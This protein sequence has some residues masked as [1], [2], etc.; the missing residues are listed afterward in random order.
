[1]SDDRVRSHASQSGHQ[2]PFVSV[3]PATKSASE[4]AA[5]SFVQYWYL[6]AAGGLT[7]PAIWPDPASTKRSG[8]WNRCV[9]F[10]T[11]SAGAIWSSRPA[12]T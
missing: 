8:P 11:L 3:A 7:T 2:L 4:S 12:C 9:I 6:P 1:M 10:H 5:A